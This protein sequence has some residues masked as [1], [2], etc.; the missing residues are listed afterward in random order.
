MKSTYIILAAAVAVSFGAGWLLKDSPDVQPVVEESK[1]KQKIKQARPSNLGGAS[2]PGPTVKSPRKTVSE[3][4]VKSEIEAPDD[5]DRDARRT[6]RRQKMST[7]MI[8]RQKEKFETKIANLVAKLGLTPQQE[9]QLRA[10][11]ANKTEAYEELM[12][13]GFENMRSMEGMEKMATVMGDD[14]LGAAMEGILSDEQLGD[15]EALKSSE[16][17]NGVETK[18]MKSMASIQ[19][20]VNLDDTQK[21]AV[22]DILYAEAEGNVDKKSPMSSMMSSFGGGMLSNIDTSVIEKRM[23]IEADTSLDADQK[24]VKVEEMQKASLDAKVSRFDGI[25]T[26]PQQTQYRQSLESQSKWMR[27]WGGG[28]RGR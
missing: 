6:E 28:R 14:D 23:V 18:A 1:A 8:D 3:P 10:H 13:G 21:D 9:K 24:K 2:A 7:R 4:V 16:R 27:G 17:K 11:Y 12:A 22:Y 20:I 25:L 5:T 19:G 26:G 15:Y